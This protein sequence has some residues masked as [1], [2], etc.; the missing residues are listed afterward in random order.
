MVSKLKVSMVKR[1]IRSFLKGEENINWTMGVIIHSRIDKETLKG[2]F[3]ELK[4]YGDKLRFE[5]ITEKC[6]N[7]GLL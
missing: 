5:D 6:K 4:N 2:V 7:R 1:A 3:D